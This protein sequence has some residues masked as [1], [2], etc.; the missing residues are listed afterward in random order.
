MENLYALNAVEGMRVRADVAGQTRHLPDG[1]VVR[2][3]VVD[4][5]EG[6]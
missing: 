1:T 5:Q 2:L 6:A 3:K 4:S